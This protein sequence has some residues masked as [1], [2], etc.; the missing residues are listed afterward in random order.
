[1]LKMEESSP[2]NRQGAPRPG[3][4]KTRQGGRNGQKRLKAAPASEFCYIMVHQD[5]VSLWSVRVLDDGTSL[6]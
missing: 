1:M 2:N 5:E 6:Y 4:K 3:T